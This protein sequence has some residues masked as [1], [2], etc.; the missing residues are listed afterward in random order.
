[1][2]FTSYA[3]VAEV[4]LKHSIRWERSVFLAPGASPLG[5][6]FRAEHDFTLANVPFDASEIA[7]RESLI[8]PLLREVWKPSAGALTLW[9]N[10]PLYYDEDLS[11]VPDY[12]VARRSLLG[13]NV[14][15]Q[16]YLMVIKA[17]KDDFP[18]GW[19][20][21]LAAMLAA[22]KL[23]DLPGL[24]YYGATTN[25]RGWEFGKLVGDR[26]TQDPR[27]YALTDLDA[28]A[29]TLHSIVIHCR[30]QA[31]RLAVSA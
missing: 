16:P 3:S 8:Y 6:H 27:G 22:Q 10:Q 29:G 23:D 9:S 5:D 1:M 13:P 20:Q 2:P 17:K 11:G 21:C 31:A 15:D 7:A 14:P 12:L 28:L 30:D 25:G 24:T 18:R 4:A 26:F 19:G